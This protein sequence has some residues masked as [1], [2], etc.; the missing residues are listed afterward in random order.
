MSNSAKEFEEARAEMEMRAVINGQLLVA[1]GNGFNLNH[2]DLPD[3]LKKQGDI[4][5]AAHHKA[6]QELVLAEFE[7]LIKP[8]E[9]IDHAY[10]RKTALQI[11]MRVRE[12]KANLGDTNGK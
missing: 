6:S 5:L 11:K 3:A 9:A 7:G 1:G 4:I 8:L 2:P 12:I 10:A